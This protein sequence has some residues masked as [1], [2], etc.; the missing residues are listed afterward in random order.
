MDA[1]L[2]F[3]QADDMRHNTQRNSHCCFVINRVLFTEFSN[4]VGVYKTF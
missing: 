4:V 3:I 2:V 1:D